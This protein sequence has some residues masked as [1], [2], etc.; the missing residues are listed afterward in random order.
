[1]GRMQSRRAKKVYFYYIL[2]ILYTSLGILSLRNLGMKIGF[3]FISVKLNLHQIWLEWDGNLFQA[4]ICNHFEG[5]NESLFFGRSSYFSST[6][7][8]SSVSGS[9]SIGMVLVVRKGFPHL[10]LASSVSVTKC[11]GT[12]EDGRYQD[13]D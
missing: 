8:C 7:I 12:S 10:Q 2:Y 5:N 3:S 6:T 13:H 9:L 1:M 4:Y 11:P